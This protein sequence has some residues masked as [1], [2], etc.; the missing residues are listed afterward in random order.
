MGY[1]L[2]S[3]PATEPVSLAEAKLHLKIETADT[4]DDTLV[5][6]LIK[7]AREQAEEYTRR[8]FIETTWERRM[9]TF[10]DDGQDGIIL[11]KK[12]PVKSITSIKYL[13]VDGVE[14]TIASTYYNLLTGDEPMGVEPAYNYSW[15][16]HREDAQRVRVQFKAGYATVPSSI[17]AALLLIIGHLYENREDVVV[18]RQVNQLPSGSRYLLDPYR[19][20]EFA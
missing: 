8:S 6:Y 1:L 18:G 2:I 15:P 12:N 20:F 14:Q 16:A 4:A 17:K 9:D 7:A 19:L 11:L 13:D 10:F 5:T 3:A